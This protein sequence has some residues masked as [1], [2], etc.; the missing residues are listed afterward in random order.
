MG[1][2]PLPPSADRLCISRQN[3]PHIMFRHSSRVGG[4]QTAG[5]WYY[6]AKPQ[7]RTTTTYWMVEK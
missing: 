3:T 2:L 5:P 7:V 1:L 4:W 6:A